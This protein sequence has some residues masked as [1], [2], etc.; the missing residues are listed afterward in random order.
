MS[1]SLL[2]IQKNTT[3]GRKVKIG[4]N[5]IIVINLAEGKGTEDLLWNENIQAIIIK[6]F[7]DEIINQSEDK[8]KNHESLNTLII[9]D[10]AH[11]LASR[12][13]KSDDE[14]FYEVRNT[15]KD[16]VRTTR[17]YGLGWM[18][19]SQ[20][21]SSLDKE[22][23]TQLRIYLF[24]F[25]LGWGTELDT[26]KEIIGGNTEAIKLYQ[27]FRDPQSSIGQKQYP[28]M[29]IGPLSPLSFSG[30]PLFF[31][32]LNCENYDSDFFKMNN[33]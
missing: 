2:R 32:A 26:L 11:R 21:L 31:T 9:I 28:F 29:G 13:I 18:F 4:T 19:I 27:S 8:F 17:K 22:I 1:G 5:T 6:E 14:Y 12:D 3:T 24:G 16:A 7:L 25:G 23:L 10:E 15:L 30:T 20:T 33:L